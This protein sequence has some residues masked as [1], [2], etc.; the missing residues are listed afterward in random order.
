VIQNSRVVEEVPLPFAGK[1]STY[2]G[3]VTLKGTGRFVIEVLAMDAANAN[4]GKDQQE[5]TVAR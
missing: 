2:A 1:T 5:I 3:Q 4:F